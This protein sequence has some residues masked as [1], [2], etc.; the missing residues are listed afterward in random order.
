MTAN[1]AV[2]R[3]NNGVFGTM[4]TMIKQLP[5]RNFGSSAVC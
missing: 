5:L 2:R 3:K 1:I 4:N